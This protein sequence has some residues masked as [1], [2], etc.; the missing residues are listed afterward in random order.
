MTAA[1]AKPRLTFWDL[2]GEATTSLLI[3][4]GRTVLTILGTV[5][6]VGALVATLGV[7]RTAG[8][9]LVTHFDALAATAITVNEYSEG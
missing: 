7:A 2:A 5:L 4:P 8:N 3:R 6:G 9:Q 1:H